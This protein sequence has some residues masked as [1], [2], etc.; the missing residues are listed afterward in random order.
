MQEAKM[1]MESCCG[2][3]VA[4]FLVPEVDRQSLRRQVE[5]EE[6]RLVNAAQQSIQQMVEM[7]R[8]LYQRTSS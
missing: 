4:Q 7:S 6:R 1:K 8:M 2:D 5:L 3:L